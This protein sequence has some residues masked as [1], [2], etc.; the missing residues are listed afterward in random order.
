MKLLATMTAAVVLAS[1][2]VAHAGAGDD[3]RV[4][5]EQINN[6]GTS[7][8]NNVVARTVGCDFGERSLGGGIRT[9]PI[10]S[11]TPA[12]Y[13]AP[14]VNGTAPFT[15]QISGQWRSRARNLGAANR[16][17]IAYAICSATS[18]ATVLSIDSSATPSNDGAM[19][20]EGGGLALCPSG[21]RAIGGGVFV[22]E[23][24][25]PATN[26]QQS[27][28]VDETAQ[29]ANTVDGDVARGWLATILTTAS[30]APVRVYALCSA[31]SLA[32][33][34]TESQEITASTAAS[35]AAICPTGTRAIS[36][37][38]TTSGDAS[39][40]V[41]VTAPSGSA[42]GPLSAPGVA[43][44]WSSTVTNGAMTRRY[45][46]S[47]VCEGPTP[48]PTPTPTDPNDPANPSPPSNA[49]TVGKLSRNRDRG[50]GMLPVTVAGPGSVTLASSK[51]KPQAIV[52]TGAGEVAVPVKAAGDAKR[53]LRRTGKLKTLVSL[54]FTP[55][56]GSAAAQESRVKLVRD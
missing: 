38:V 31:S 26:I 2:G 7:N 1:T 25:A 33:V 29:P 52:A 34:Q 15:G 30:G 19:L 48:T 37:G 39:S 21:Q 32:T 47:A 16:N 6:V 3:A 42:G 22:D 50:T 5:T 40:S 14:F 54:T 8:P 41:S 53:K 10:H 55:S 49:F 13:S 23:F 35:G 44:G 4:V 56:G 9:I 51:L 18:D 43:Q 46:F 17:F 36:G 27:G 11:D 12:S 24:G 20:F 45:H 28:P